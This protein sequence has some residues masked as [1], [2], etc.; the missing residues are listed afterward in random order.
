M[1]LFQKRGAI[2]L[3]II[4]H[5]VTVILVFRHSKLRFLQITCLRCTLFS[6]L[7]IRHTTASLHKR[8]LI[9]II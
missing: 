7:V 3:R 9:K 4:Q 2:Q 8:Q 6:L 1:I 5:K